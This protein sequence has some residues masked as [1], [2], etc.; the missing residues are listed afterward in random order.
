MTYKWNIAGIIEK[1]FATI[2]LQKF[3][4]EVKII[5]LMTK[6]SMPI[7]LIDYGVGFLGEYKIFRCSTDIKLD[8]PF[9][10]LDYTSSPC[11][12]IAVTYQ[13]NIVGHTQENYTFIEPEHRGKGI[14]SEILAEFHTAYP[15]HAQCRTKYNGVRLYTE[16][17]L[18]SLTK[19]YNLMVER[20]AIVGD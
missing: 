17:G 6:I 14:G 16:S 1:P 13:D 18:K 8:S 20:S 15:I 12:G 2:S 9:Y 7:K 5:K 4:G 3:L 10:T 19:A 11:Y